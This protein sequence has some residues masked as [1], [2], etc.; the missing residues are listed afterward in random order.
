VRDQLGMGAG[1]DDAAFV[2][3]DDPAGGAHG[4]EPVC[5]H[6]RGA[7]LHQ[8]LERVLDQAFAFGVERGGG[9]VEQ[10]D[11]RVAEQCAG[12][13]ETLALA[14]REARAAFAEESVEALGQFAEEIGGI[15]GIGGGPERSS[16]ASQAP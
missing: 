11:R 2:H 5:D 10:Q 3:H 12:D 1:L 7:V 9:F 4:G 8:P 6:Q 16:P 14:A 13:G 15:G